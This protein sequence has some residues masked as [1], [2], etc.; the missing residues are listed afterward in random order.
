MSRL[1]NVIWFREDT[2]HHQSTLNSESRMHHK[3]NDCMYSNMISLFMTLTYIIRS[4]RYTRYIEMKQR[5][6]PH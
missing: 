2:T 6:N 3:L 5:G 1:Y 4:E